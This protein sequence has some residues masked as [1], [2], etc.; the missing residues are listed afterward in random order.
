MTPGWAP[1]VVAVDRFP[2]RYPSRESNMGSKLSGSQLVKLE[3]LE[4][5]RRKWDRVRKLIEQAATSPKT[6][7][8]FMRQCHRTAS[9][10]GRFLANN[11]FGPL[12]TYALDLATLIKRPGT[13]ESKV[14][15]LREMVGRGYVGFDRAQRDIQRAKVDSGD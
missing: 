15:A 11:A 10:V 8:E 14:G 12:S 7:G 1:I 9:E 4:E 13:Y 6:Q 2:G 5:A 3:S